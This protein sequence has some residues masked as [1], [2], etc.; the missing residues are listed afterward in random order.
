MPDITEPRPLRI[1]LVWFFAIAIGSA[2]L[3][4]AVAEGLRLLILH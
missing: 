2:A 4:A 1:R 3:T